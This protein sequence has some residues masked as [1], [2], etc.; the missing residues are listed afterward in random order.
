MGGPV[1]APVPLVTGGEAVDQIGEL[2]P[3]GGL[4]RSGDHLDPIVATLPG[5]LQQGRPGVGD[6]EQR[7]T[8]IAG[9]STPFQQPE[10]N[11][12][13]SLPADRGRV[14]VHRSSE[15]GDP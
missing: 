6:G 5:A 7:R 13:G 12:M 3:F 1:G 8:P 4:P 14:G 10:I 9:V 11:K 15:H 2:L